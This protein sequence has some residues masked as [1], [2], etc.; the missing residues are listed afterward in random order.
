GVSEA[1]MLALLHVKGRLAQREGHEIQ[2]GVARM[3]ADGEDRGKRRLQALV[4]AAFGRDMRLQ[5]GRV[6]LK[7]GGEQEGHVQHARPLGK[8]LADALLFGGGIRGDSGHGR[9]RS[10]IPGNTSKR[11]K[12][13]QTPAAWASC[14]YPLRGGKTTAGGRGETPFPPVV[15]LAA[16]LN[17]GLGA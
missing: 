11:L 16:L 15:L 13:P 5:E 8:A 7:L 4:L 6:G 12:T 1:A 10:E 3:A 14:F 17:L 9:S 2:A